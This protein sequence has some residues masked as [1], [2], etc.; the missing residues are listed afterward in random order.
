[1]FSNIL[2]ICLFSFFVYIFFNSFY[3]FESLLKSW[4]FV[5]KYDSTNIKLFWFIDLIQCL[6]GLVWFGLVSLF[7][8]ISTPF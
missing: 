7:N 5:W 6:F 3:Y 4:S 8:G 2:P 1:M